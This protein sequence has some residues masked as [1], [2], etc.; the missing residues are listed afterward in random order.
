MIALNRFSTCLTYRI[1]HFI[2]IAKDPENSVEFYRLNLRDLG[3][4]H[5]SFVV[6]QRQKNRT[7]RA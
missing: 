1:F 3:W 6:G 4:S 5:E 2:V 7:L